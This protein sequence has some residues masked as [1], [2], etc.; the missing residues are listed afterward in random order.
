VVVEIGFATSGMRQ[1]VSDSLTDHRNDK[2]KLT[3]RNNKSNCPRPAFHS[4][5]R[6]S[7]NS[8]C[9]APLPL[10]PR[11][12]VV[13]WRLWQCTAGWSSGS[14]SPA[15]KLFA[16]HDGRVGI[17]CARQYDESVV[18]PRCEVRVVEES[19]WGDGCGRLVVSNDQFW[20]PFLLSSRPIKNERLNSR[21]RTTQ[22]GT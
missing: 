8:R 11:A 9:S 10:G 13:R 14:G 12:L 7:K 18:L 21:V 1:Y 19:C 22:L 6:S 4:R 15:G 3:L 17:F 5:Y 2:E 16:R 20:P